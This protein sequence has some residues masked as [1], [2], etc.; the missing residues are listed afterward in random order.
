MNQNKLELVNATFAGLFEEVV[1]ILLAINTDEDPLT[2]RLPDEDTLDIMSA[3]EIA[4]LVARA[5]NIY[6]KAARLSGMAKQEVKRAQHQYNYAYKTNKHGKNDDQRTANAMEAAKDEAE[7]LNL[8]ERIYSIAEDVAGAAKLS[9][10]SARML[11][12]KMESI[13]IAEGRERYGQERQ[14]RP[15][16]RINF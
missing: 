7:Q 5:S 16:E 3:A 14:T 6:S 15:A 10:E 9:S 2:I 13:H 12:N 8:A 4:K 1:D 11:L